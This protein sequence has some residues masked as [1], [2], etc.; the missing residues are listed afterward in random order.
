M[1]FHNF[2]HIN[3]F[4]DICSSINV[5]KTGPTSRA[6]WTQKQ[7]Q[8]DS[9]QPLKPGFVV[10]L[11]DRTGEPIELIGHTHNQSVFI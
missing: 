8:I 4:L 10:E 2:L 6:S 11:H 5:V 7:S 1:S 9:E 3:G